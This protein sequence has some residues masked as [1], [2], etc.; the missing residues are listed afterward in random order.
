[1]AQKL[2]LADISDLRE[3]E[4]ERA[5][6]REHIIAIKQRRRVE[7]GPVITLTFENRDT[8]RFQV[9]EIMRAERIVL[10]DRIRVEVETYNELVPGPGQLFATVLI[11]ITDREHLRQ[12]LDRLIGIDRG[13]TTFLVVGGD[14]IEGEYE[15]GHSNEVRVSAVHY[16]TFDVTP[17]QAKAIAPG[18]PPVSLVIEHPNYHAEQPLSDDAR[19]QLAADLT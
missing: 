19:A 2:T 8:V 3:Y 1:M 17:E 15:G 14:R 16:V 4:R 7:L 5:E 11:E 9:Q 6:F 10:E 12:I 13:G 18:G